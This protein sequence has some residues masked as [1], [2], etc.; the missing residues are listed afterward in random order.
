MSGQTRWGTA[1]LGD[2]LASYVSGC[3]IWVQRDQRKLVYHVCPVAGVA[4]AYL[5]Y[6]HAFLPGD[7]AT[8]MRRRSQLHGERDAPTLAA[9]KSPAAMASCAAEFMK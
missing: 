9:E 3:G 4:A 5:R 7:P 8:T 6:H 1:V 2:L